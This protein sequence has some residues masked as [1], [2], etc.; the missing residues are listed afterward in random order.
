[1]LE[2]HPV[3]L[4]PVGEIIAHR[5][6]NQLLRSGSCNRLVQVNDKRERLAPGIFL[7]PTDNKFFRIM[8]EIPL[9]KWRRIPRIKTLFDSIDEYLD[10]I[11]RPFSDFEVMDHSLCLA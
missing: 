9:V 10:A 11:R 1:M 7:R 6:F 8:I 4:S 5:P 2:L 3:Q